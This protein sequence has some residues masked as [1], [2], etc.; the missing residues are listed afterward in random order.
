MSIFV[1]VYLYSDMGYDPYC[2]NTSVIV[3]LYGSTI[4]DPYRISRKNSLKL[5]G[6]SGINKVSLVLVS[7]CMH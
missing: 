4:D 1:P 3:T 7:S 5:I 6:L 2:N